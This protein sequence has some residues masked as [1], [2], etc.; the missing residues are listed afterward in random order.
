MESVAPSGYR[1]VTPGKRA[2]LWMALCLVGG[3]ACAFL[4]LEVAGIPY[5]VV[6]LAGLVFLS[7]RFD[8]LAES[9]AA[10]GL[11]FTLVA[12]RFGLPNIAFFDHR[13]D[14]TSS[15]FFGLVVLIGIAFIVVA[16]LIRRPRRWFRR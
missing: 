2:G 8:L 16:V 13:G 4:T 3:A 9:L 11:S 1:S 15:F 10:F 6:F 7:R 12:A 14:L 5:V